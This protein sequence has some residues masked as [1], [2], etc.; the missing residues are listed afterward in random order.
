V[1]PDEFEQRV[2]SGLASAVDQLA[3]PIGLRAAAQRRIRERA[4]RRVA[5]RVGGVGAAGLMTVA[6][7]AWARRGPDDR[8]RV[9]SGPTT[10][11]A[12]SA[13]PTDTPQRSTSSPR[14]ADQPGAL[15]TLSHAENILV[16]GV[17]DNACSDPDSPFAGGIGDRTT[18]GYRAD[19][20]MVL[21]LDPTARAA[22]L[23]SFPRDLWIKAPGRGSIRISATA[24]RG[25][26]DVIA[27]VLDENFGI[28]VDHFVQVDFCAFKTLVDAV[29]G[30][31]IPIPTAIRDSSTGLA[32]PAGCHSFSG[33]EALAYVRSRHLQALDANGVWQP[34]G[35]S[36]FGRIAREQDLVQRLLRTVMT[37]G[38]LD[39]SLARGL[40]AAVQQS[41]VVDQALTIDAMIGI[42]QLLDEIGPDHIETHQIPAIAATVANSAV[43]RPDL[44]DP[45]T[46]AMLAV[47]RGQPAP[48]VTT[49]TPTVDAAP[50]SVT[51]AIRPDSAA[52]C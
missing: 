50:S 8:P 49:L 9:T 5:I 3:T 46:I 14:T 48:A 6:G 40:L 29:G 13:A 34:D 31:T 47:F 32:V 42:G 51:D 10:A 17:D 23:L 12:T 41:I 7:L 15:P 39:P 52:T 45:A 25:Q 30:I 38:L 24:Q 11:P 20:I 33:D 35:S 22:S 43:L 1:S 2:R 37:R 4:R 44:T 19:T 16:M 26:Y 27:A 21:H 28:R 18:A 36:D